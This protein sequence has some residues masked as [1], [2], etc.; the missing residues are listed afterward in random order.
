MVQDTC[1]TGHLLQVIVDDRSSRSLADT[2]AVQC[3]FGKI[4]SYLGDMPPNEDY[5]EDM[6]YLSLLGEENGEHPERL[7]SGVMRIAVTDGQ[8][9]AKDSMLG[10]FG[11][12]LTNCAVEGKLDPVIGRDAEIE[13]VI[14]ILGRRKKEQPG[15]DRRS[16]RREV[17]HHRRAGAADH[18]EESPARTVAQTDLSLDVASLVA[19]TKYRG[20]FEERINLLLK[21][22]SGSDVILFIDE[23]HDRRRR[24]HARVARHGQHPETGAGP[25]R[26][27]VHRSHHPERIPR[28]ISKATARW[29]GVFRR[30]SW[31]S[32]R[33]KRRCVC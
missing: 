25:G 5:Y 3:D 7:V 13:R 27:A 10:Q 14:Q 18:A 6:Q 24:Q 17:G 33:P 11:V 28:K 20:Q 1:N 22:L 15:A 9:A 23:I 32:R 12:D 19:G 16:G 2:G 4:V 29:S 21:E 30:S 26:T 8:P 31:N